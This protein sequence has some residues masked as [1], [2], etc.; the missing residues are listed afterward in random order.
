MCTK[1]IHYVA[2]CRF[3]RL[4]RFP[5][6][7]NQTWRRVIFTIVI[8][9]EV[10][11]VAHSKNWWIVPE[12][13]DIYIPIEGFSSYFAVDDDEQVYMGDSRSS[14]VAG[15][16]EVLLKLTL[17]K[18]L[19]SCKHAHVLKIR[20]DLISVS[21]LV[22]IG[23]KVYFESDKIVIIKNKW[24]V[25]KGYCIQGFFYAWYIWDHE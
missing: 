21:F 13:Y 19:L 4:V 9:V 6:S 24:F 3:G 14:P 22:K 1:L 2:K 10:N 8:L 25:G 7:H 16:N 11:I 18:I 20:W 5:S 23:V 15:Q 17:G 12:Q